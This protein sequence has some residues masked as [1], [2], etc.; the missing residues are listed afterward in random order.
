MTG[1][2]RLRIALFLSLFVA[3][4]AQAQPAGYGY[5]R[6]FRIQGAQ[7]AGNAPLTNFPVLISLT[8]AN[9]RTTANGGRMQSATAND[10]VFTLADCSTVLPHQL[11]RYV[12]S[13]GELITWVR[14]PQLTPGQDL[15]ILMFYGRANVTV[16]P[17]TSAVWD[18]DYLGVWHFNG[19]VNDATS[20]SRNLTDASTATHASSRIGE[21]RDLNNSSDI[22]SNN[23]GRHLR[24][25]DN[26]LNNASNF[27]FEG[28]MY[29]DRSDTNW[30]RIF[31]FGPSTN[32]NFFFTPSHGTG[33]PAET[34]SRIT[35]SGN[36]NEQGPVIANSATQA[37]AWVHWAVTYDA[38][39][40]LMRVF[41]NGAAYG[42]ASVSIPLSA[43]GNNGPHYFG[44][45]KYSADHYIDAK[46]DE[47]RISRTAR[48]P[49]YLLT[50]YRNQNAPSSFYT[51]SNEYT[52]ANLCLVALP[53]ELLEFDARP[54][55]MDA[56][57]VSWA[58]A[59]ERNNRH[60]TVE[61]SGDG[62]SWEDLATLTGAGNSTS[63][64]QYGWRDARPAPGTSY[65]RLRQ[66]DMDGATTTSA[67]RVVDRPFADAVLYPN[68]AEDHFTLMAKGP[69]MVLV[70]DAAGRVVASGRANAPVAIAHLAPGSYRVVADPEA[71]GRISLPLRIVR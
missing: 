15:T 55:G 16:S 9:L 58:T 67:V 21:G 17:S 71:C 69:G 20:N 53:V 68:P 5:G 62:Q 34:R 50:T 45:S 63:R 8:H 4:A 46:F 40:Q 60:F 52:A 25:P 31:D 3:T 35:T 11:E 41:R 13:T 18:A 2:G 48:S 57:L 42:S 44:R 28:W 10:I 33:D 7:I 38:G 19:N 14:V 32:V 29:L 51:A 6:A 12:A 49:E 47:F 27:S 37:G 64:V 70:M 1:P 24:M 54:E 56:V 65:Y 66:T 23:A 30:E 26:I 22:L 43:M 39:A 36:A 61:R 59:S